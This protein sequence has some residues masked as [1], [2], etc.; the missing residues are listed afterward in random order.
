MEL[1][2]GWLQLLW[3]QFF[4]MPTGDI[5]MIVL[6]L[7]IVLP[8]LFPLFLAI[9][10]LEAIL[11]KK[12]CIGKIQP[13]DI[14]LN[15]VAYYRW[16]LNKGICSVAALAGPGRLLP[17]V[18]N[19]MG[20]NVAHDIT[21]FGEI[22]AGCAELLE[23]GEGAYISAGATLQCTRLQGRVLKMRHVTAKK[24]T[25]IGEASLVSAGSEVGEGTIL[26][27]GT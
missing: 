23:I 26:H 17:F 16:W 15:S 19:C 5:I 22:E 7:G 1:R 18:L 14:P 20:A 8:L 10:L 24:G 2:L 9:A 27:P 11:V 13:E 25:Y 4:A 12:L 6:V 21:I 3:T